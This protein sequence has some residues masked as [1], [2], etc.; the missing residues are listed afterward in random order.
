MPASGFSPYPH[1]SSLGGDGETKKRLTG[2]II[3]L[4]SG[5]ESPLPR[6]QPCGPPEGS[7]AHIAAA[8]TLARGQ[9]VLFAT[10]PELLA[11]IRERFDAGQAEDLTGVCQRVP[12][13]VVDDLGRSG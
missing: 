3:P 4:P 12:W 1:L 10:A 2:A 7:K 11:M 9:A 13:L 5:N 6:R 8:N